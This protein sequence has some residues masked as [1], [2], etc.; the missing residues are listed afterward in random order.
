MI[1]VWSPGGMYDQCMITRRYFGFTMQTF[2]LLN[3]LVVL[4]RCNTLNSYFS[5]HLPSKVEFPY[6]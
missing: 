1:N 6:N 5:G 4:V 2:T 3:R